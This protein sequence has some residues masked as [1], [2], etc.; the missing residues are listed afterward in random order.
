MNLCKRRDVIMTD[1]ADT[2]HGFPVYDRPLGLQADGTDDGR[3]TMWI[4]D[5]S[6]CQPR[7]R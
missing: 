3:S 2:W 4:T 7:D 6:A 5:F 1:T